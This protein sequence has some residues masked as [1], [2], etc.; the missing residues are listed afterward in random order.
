[1]KIK[2]QYIEDEGLVIQR[3]TGKCNHEDYLIYLKNITTEPWWNSIKKIL[4]D[5]R[6]FDMIPC[7]N[8]IKKVSEANNKYITIAYHNVQIVN[9]PRATAITHLFQHEVGDSQIIYDYCSTLEH[10]IQSLD[11]NMDIDQI[12]SIIQSL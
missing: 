6:S 7:I 10:A 4:T 2:Y 3:Y 5:F 8:N 12:E 9:A 11:I 1:M